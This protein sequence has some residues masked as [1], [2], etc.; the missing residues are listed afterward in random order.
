M[1]ERAEQAAEKALRAEAEATVAP[2]LFQQ[3]EKALRQKRR[4][5]NSFPERAASV[6]G[7]A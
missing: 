7:R 1:E 4:L 2:V 5:F 3:R 6:A